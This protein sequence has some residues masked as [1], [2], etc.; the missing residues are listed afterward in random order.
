MSHEQ[1]TICP[2]LQHKN[3]TPTLPILAIQENSIGK[4]LTG[5]K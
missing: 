2:E 3:D 1:K 4:D 5:L